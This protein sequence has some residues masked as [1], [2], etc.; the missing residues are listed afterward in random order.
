MINNRSK[1]EQEAGRSQKPEEIGEGARGTDRLNSKAW[2]GENTSYHTW[3]IESSGLEAGDWAVEVVWGQTAKLTV[4]VTGLN[5][6]KGSENLLGMIRP[7]EVSEP[8]Q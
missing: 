3:S 5:Y 4:Q 2:Q 6:L 1:N 7:R 8:Q